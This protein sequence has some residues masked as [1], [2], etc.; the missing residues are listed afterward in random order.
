LYATVLTAVVG[1]L[2]AAAVP[3][4][5][6]LSS[7]DAPEI[8]VS[9]SSDTLSDLSY[10]FADRF[11]DTPSTLPPD[12]VKAGK[13]RMKL[14]IQ[15]ST[16]STIRILDLRA[17]ILERKAPLGGTLVKRIS[18]GS[19]SEVMG[20][21]LWQDP[22][23]ARVLSGDGRLGDPFFSFQSIEIA[24]SASTVLEITVAADGN[25]Y[26]YQLELVYAREGRRHAVTVDTTEY[27]VSG[28]A[29][30]YS[31]AYEQQA[32]SFLPMN[33]AETRSFT[34]GRNGG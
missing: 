32:G 19:A 14:L 33:E 7:P 24:D 6:G 21:G 27:E 26:R 15:N 22:P 29:P 12:G 25:H 3:W 34:E 5:G 17:M 16:G 1:V 31:Y 28:Y 18:Q 20:I 4:F 8:T 2:V 9:D 23:I 10:V 13:A 30:T 11:S